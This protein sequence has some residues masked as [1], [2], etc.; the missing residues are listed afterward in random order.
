MD[1]LL[2]SWC[3]SELGVGRD[4]SLPTKYPASF[5]MFPF[6]RSGGRRYWRG[7]QQFHLDTTYTVC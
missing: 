2:V 1:L 4:S 5:H 6:R 7:T 3:K